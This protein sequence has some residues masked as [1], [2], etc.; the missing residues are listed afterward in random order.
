M[1]IVTL[2]LTLPLEGEG[3]FIESGEGVCFA[4]DGEASARFFGGVGP[5]LPGPLGL[6]HETG[7]QLAELGCV[8]R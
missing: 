3:I 8:S 2:S 7:E 4:F 6:S 5:D 1:R